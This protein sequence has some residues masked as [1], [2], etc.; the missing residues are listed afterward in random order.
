MHHPTRL[1]QVAALVAAGCFQAPRRTLHDHG[2]ETLECLKR[3]D[4]SRPEFLLS[5]QY[6]AARVA[7]L[8]VGRVAGPCGRQPSTAERLC[9]LASMRS[10][11]RTVSNFSPNVFCR[12]ASNCSSAV[13]LGCSFPPLRK[14]NQ[15]D[16]LVTIERGHSRLTKSGN[17]RR[18]PLLRSDWLRNCPFGFT[19]WYQRK[20]YVGVI[21]PTA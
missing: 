9:T 1:P 11:A 14:E 2:L 17:G 18:N 19:P 21:F 20:K 4:R 10:D 16:R 7:Q 12:S 13:L 5:V 6:T 8:Q 3:R 15:N